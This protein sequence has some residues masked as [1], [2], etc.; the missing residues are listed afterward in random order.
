MR[1]RIGHNGPP[2]TSNVQAAAPPTTAALDKQPH[3]IA[4]MFDG[5]ARRY[6]LTNTVLSFG[7]DRRWRRRTRQCLELR[8]G[9]RVL[10]L[11]AGTGGVDRGAAP[12]PARAPSAAT[13][14]S[15]CCGPGGR[16]RR[17]RSIPFVAG[18]A[19]RAAVRRRRVRRGDDLLRAAQRRRRRRPRC[20]RWPGWCGPAAGWWSASSAGRRWRAVPLRLPELPDA[21]AAVDRPARVLEPG[22]LRL[23]RRVDPSLAGA[24]RSWPHTIADA[25]G[26]PTSGTA[27][28][29]AG[30]SRCTWPTERRADAVWYLT[31]SGNC[32]RLRSTSRAVTEMR[33]R[34]DDPA[35]TT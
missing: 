31:T 32:G 5:V 17:R 15:A 22:R 27:T 10:D 8:P 28:S 13:S 18:D 23:P 30:S 34:H 4:A 1:L 2:M 24:G 9:Q 29:P 33:S 21:G 14:R 19:M 12:C 3:E 20:A 11:A 16:N 35:T 25:A 26:G 6:D 7:L